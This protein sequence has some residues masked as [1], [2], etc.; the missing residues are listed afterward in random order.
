M[1]MIK[2]KNHNQD[3][4]MHNK[5][6]SPIKEAKGFYHLESISD[7]L[8]HE[9]RESLFP[10][11]LELVPQLNEVYELELDISLCAAANQCDYLSILLQGYAHSSIQISLRPVMQPTVYSRI[12]ANSIR[13]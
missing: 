2:Q 4:K 3:K 10:R 8:S 13:R 11:H 5:R 6:V 7:I 12:E 9:A 1:K